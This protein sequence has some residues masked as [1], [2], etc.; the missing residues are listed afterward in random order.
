M[1]FYPFPGTVVGANHQCAGTR[2]ALK[3]HPLHHLVASVGWMDLNSEWMD[4]DSEV[5]AV[6][7]NHRVVDSGFCEVVSDCPS[8]V[9]M[10]EWAIL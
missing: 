9:L 7:S 1:C 8:A 2:V 6:G 4:L 3:S 10:R 5:L